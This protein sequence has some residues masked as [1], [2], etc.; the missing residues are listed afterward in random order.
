MRDPLHYPLC[1]QIALHYFSGCIALYFELGLE[2]NLPLKFHWH[3]HFL[4]L[5]CVVLRRSVVLWLLVV[6]RSC[7]DRSW[8]A[9]FNTLIVTLCVVLRRRRLRYFLIVVWSGSQSSYHIFRDLGRRALRQ[10]AHHHLWVT[11]HVSDHLAPL[12]IICS[13]GWESIFLSV[14]FFSFRTVLSIIWRNRVIW[15]SD[16]RLAWEAQSCS[17]NR[18]NILNECALS[19]LLPPTS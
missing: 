10:H 4:N 12:W 13:V 9:L 7:S 18:R 19:L 1:K 3:L 17:R 14:P 5:S 11:S 8:V 16:A 2:S 15:I 6:E